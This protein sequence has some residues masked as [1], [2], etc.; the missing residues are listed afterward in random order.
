MYEQN[1]YNNELPEQPEAS[2]AAPPKKKRHLV[3]II[4]LSIIAA[5]CLTLCIIFIF[6]YRNRMRTVT[7]SVE[8]YTPEQLAEAVASARSDARED[9]LSDIQERLSNGTSVNS[10]LRE[11]FPDK[12]VY[13]DDNRYIFADIHKELKMNQLHGTFE[14]SDSG[15]ITYL[16]NGQL[17]SHKGIDVS[18]YQ[19]SI[20]F[21]KVHNSGVE[22]VMIRC[23]Y[24]AY[25]SGLLT[26]DTSFEKNITSALKNELDVGVYFFTQA[27]SAAE[28]VEEADFVLDMIRPYQIKYPIALDVEE[29]AGDTYRQ[30]DLSAE[31]L[32]DIIIAFCERI[33]E[34]GYT[35]LVYGN[36]KCFA[37][38]IDIT[39]LEPYEKWFAYYSDEPYMPYEFSMW[40]YTSTGKIDGINGDVDINISFKTWD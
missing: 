15:E 37:G 38:M 39:R 9:V 21:S 4:S 40:Q 11:Y 3:I 28:A 22:Y 19:G 35:P 5:V 8:T 23:G 17:L 14:Q 29:I 34:A 27:I 10:L 32:T 31:E 16:E 13:T 18:R 1:N 6:I 12:I 7:A 30:Q 25:G 33:K 2:T 36:L 20:D 24:R 26:A